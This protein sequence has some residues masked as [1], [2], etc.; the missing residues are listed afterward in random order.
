[1]SPELKP[2]GRKK[3]KQECPGTEGGS[4]IEHLPSMYEALG[5]STAK[6]EKKG[7]GKKE[8]GKEEKKRK[9]NLPVTLKVSY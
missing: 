8:G 6:K 7:K 3:K 1:V 2:Q 9:F 4:V 5:S